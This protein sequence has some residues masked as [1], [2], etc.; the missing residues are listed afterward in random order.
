[1]FILF[2]ILLIIIISFKH[3]NSQ[4]EN[5]IGSSIEYNYDKVDPIYLETPKIKF[6]DSHEFQEFNNHD[7][8]EFLI[9]PI[10][11]TKLKGYNSGINYKKLEKSDFEKKVIKDNIKTWKCRNEISRPWF[12]C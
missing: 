9:D 2:L 6:N 7:Y 8:D 3:S 10:L 11:N 1:M 12:F 4:K 5:F